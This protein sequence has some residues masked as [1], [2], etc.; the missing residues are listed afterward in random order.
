MTDIDTENTPKSQLAMLC[1]NTLATIASPPGRIYAA[2]K[3]VVSPTEEITDAATAA[4]KVAK[5]VL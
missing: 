5:S 2:H 3:L 4:A 1:A